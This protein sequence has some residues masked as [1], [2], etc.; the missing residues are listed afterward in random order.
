MREPAPCDPGRRRVGVVASY[1]FTRQ[2]ELRRWLPARVAWT[3]TVTDEVPYENNLE[4]VSRLGRPG[5]L[6]GPVRGLVDAGAEAVAYLCTAGSFAGGVPGERALR[7]AIRRSGARHAVTTSGAVVAALHALGA[8][9]LAV[10]HPYQQPVDRLLA[11]YLRAH[12]FDLV[13]LTA[14]GLDTV[15]DVYAVA[16]DQV[17]DVV[18]R[19]DRP[20]AD[21][22]FVSCT[23]LPTYDALPR[24]EERLGKPVVSADQAT[25]WALLGAVGER[26]YGPGQRLLGTRA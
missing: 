2:D 1:D 5:L 3:M 17:A 6:S 18:A 22:V 11:A 23:A 7:E 19:A 26:A 20:E 24:L 9:R 14:L 4:L 10:V 13:A 15:E 16:A 21:A 25:V 8:R 12:G